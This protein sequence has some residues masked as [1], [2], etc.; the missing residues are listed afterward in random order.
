MIKI[1]LS[2]FLIAWFESINA[3]NKIDRVNFSMQYPSEW[4]VDTKD[5]DYDPDALFSIDS[6][7]GENMIMF[8]I[9]DIAANTAV[10]M[11]EQ[12]KV[13]TDLLIKKPEISHFDTWGKY[14]GS[15][16]TLKGK[17]MG[18]FKGVVRIFVYTDETKTMTVVEQFYDKNYEVLKK[19]YDF[20]SSTFQFKTSK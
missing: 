19:D 18:V 8:V 7:D 13:F 17:L 2:L 9:F 12:I 11:K 16:T 1:L 4:R 6:P 3:Q 10:I 14:N 20:M 15:G 5:E